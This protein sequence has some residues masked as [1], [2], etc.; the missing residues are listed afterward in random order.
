MNQHVLEPSGI[1]CTLSA[2]P[3]ASYPLLA[4]PFSSC[5]KQLDCLSS[6]AG[7]ASIRAW[8]KHKKEVFPLAFPLAGYAAKI[9]SEYASQCWSTANQRVPDSTKVFST[10]HYSRKQHGYFIQDVAFPQTKIGPPGNSQFLHQT[11]PA[12]MRPWLLQVQ[13]AHHCSFASFKVWDMRMC[14]VSFDHCVV[15]QNSPSCPTGGAFPNNGARCQSQ[16]IC[17]AQCP[18]CPMLIAS[19]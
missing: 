12:A 4:S 3:F 16:T 6:L 17:L 1:R 15:Q 8:N 19:G 11:C 18:F 2:P 14:C 9:C 5:L 13:P 7:A 10:I